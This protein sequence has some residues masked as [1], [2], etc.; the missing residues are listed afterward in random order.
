MAGEQVASLAERCAEAGRLS[1][2]R[3]LFRK[4]SVSDLAI[5]E[6]SVIASVKGSEGNQYETTISTAMAPPGVARQI[7]QADKP[8]NR[9]SVDDLL[10]EGLDICPGEIDLVFDCECADWDE[11][12]KH[13]V[14][15]LLAFADRV[16]LDES[17][18]LRWRGIDLSIRGA[19]AVE[20]PP[21]WASRKR[22]R[23]TE[24]P[25][26]SNRSSVMADGGPTET[27][28][29]P[30][31]RPEAEAETERQRSRSEPGGHDSDEPEHPEDRSA[32]LSEL[33]ALLGNTVVRVS[34]ADD[35]ELEPL[36]VP[37]EPVLAEFLGVGTTIQP[38][39]VGGIPVPSP[40]FP[41]AELGPLADLGPELKKAISII[42]KRLEETS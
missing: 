36:P 37:L 11:P 28:S 1:R 26:P 5:L 8:E 20:P 22:N 23:K 12:C 21:S 9:R 25:A 17:E 27:K 4:G 7:A 41:D 13:V 19:E 3:A 15:V 40:L 16:D 35:S 10:G 38:P 6:G 29:R 2:G 31:P 34:A 33:E 18:L 32:K 39:E 24:D 30:K 14:A 42:R